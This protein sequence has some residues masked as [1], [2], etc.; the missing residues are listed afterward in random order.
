MIYEKIKETALFL[1]DRIKTKP[2]IGIVCGSGLANIVEKIESK[3]IIPYSSIPNF[4]ISTV[5]GHKSNLIF[6]TLAGR[7]VIAMQGRF[8]YYEGYSMEQV[9]FPIRIMKELGVKYLIITNAS[10]GVNPLFHS[11]DLMIIED[12]I[13]L[14]PNPLIG[15]NDE[16]LGIRFPAMNK[17]YSPL[18]IEKAE[19]VAK[20]NNIKIHKGVYLGL[21]GPSFE[22]PAEYVFFR[23]AGASCVGMSTVPEVIVGVH[24]NMEVFALSLISN[25]FKEDKSETPTMAEVIQSG[26]DAQE[27]IMV[28][29]EQLVGEI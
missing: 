25:I 4:P 5:E 12:H 23:N 27:K 6:G 20:R 13:N 28:L 8:H 9:T 7:N 18:L 1:Q 29:I 24:S 17:A 11:G 2:L 10:G 26:K 15:P 19:R 16:R 22:T 21:T 14:L 3:T